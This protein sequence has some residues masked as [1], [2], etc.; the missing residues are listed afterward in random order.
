M[1]F[2]FR[3]F[4]WYNLEMAIH[5]ITLFNTLKKGKEK[6]EPLL[7]GHVSIYNCG[8]TVYNYAHIGNLRAYIAT[9]ILRR[10][11]EFNEYNVTQVMNITDVGHLQSDADDGEDKMTLA[12][13]REKLA[14][15]LENMRTVANKF[16]DAFRGDMEELNIKPAHYFP[17][18]S[19]HIEDDI[20][21]VQHLLDNGHAYKT[22]DGVYFDTNSIR[23]YGK[24]GGVATDESLANP[25]DQ[26][27]RIGDDAIAKSQKKNFRDFALWKFN[28]ALGY[29]A[30]FGKGFPGWHIECSVMSMKYLGDTFDIHTGGVDHISP[31]HNNEIAQS[32]AKSGKLLANYWL[33]NEHI[34]LE[35]GKKMAKSGENFFILSEIKKQ[36]VSPMG[37]RYWILSASYRSKLQ[38]SLDALK[39]AEQAYQNVVGRVANILTEVGN[40]ESAKLE[41]AKKDLLHIE[42]GDQENTHFDHWLE[43]F[44]LGV[45]DDLDTA[46]GLAILQTLLKNTEID[47]ETKI[48]LIEVFDLVLGLKLIE[49]ATDK[50]AAVK[51]QSLIPLP[52][53][54]RDLAEKRALAK[55]EKDWTESDRLRDEI[56]SL[57]YDITDNGDEYVISKKLT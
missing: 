43:K 32:E 23:D 29:G 33:H 44:T 7:P 47:A 22:D 39:Q 46:G 28:K 41:K 3:R 10:V 12:L 57:G 11:F 35:G 14:L 2:M 1:C 5:P 27:S 15:T 56:N 54:V 9:D 6:F 36:G 34:I 21:F 48:K 53:S 8:P 52:D 24:L 31:H 20:D 26:Q 19:D 55:K 45:N 17:F 4:L 50:W 38:F 49:N 16:Y 51:E 18:A 40:A 13:R 42:D 25:E 30:P 37:L